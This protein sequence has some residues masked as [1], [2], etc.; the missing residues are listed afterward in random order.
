MANKTIDDLPNIMSSISWQLKRIA[1][2]LERFNDQQETDH[3]TASDQKP[4]TSNK[5]RDY[6]SR[7]GED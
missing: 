6:L 2:E 3:K 1:E 4:I 7:L 5:I